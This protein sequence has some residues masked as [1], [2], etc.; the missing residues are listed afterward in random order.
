M[1]LLWI[2]LRKP[3]DGVV[4]LTPDVTRLLSRYIL[5]E[6]AQSN[7]LLAARNY[8][9]FTALELAI[10]GEKTEAV[11]MLVHSSSLRA[12]NSLHGS[13]LHVAAAF[14]LAEVLR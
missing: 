14:G 6:C 10:K 13:P 1:R 7:S 2:A 9:D 12:N 4:H 11:A 5:R 8:D 3:N